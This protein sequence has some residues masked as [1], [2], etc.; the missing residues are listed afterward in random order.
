LLPGDPYR[1]IAWKASGRLGKWVVKEVEQE[2]QNTLWL[3]VDISGTMRHGEWGER[4]L[5]RAIEW[6]ASQA[7]S[8]LKHGGQVGLITF[9]SRVVSVVDCGE[10]SSHR[11][12][13]YEALLDSTEVTDADLTEED[14][15][16]VAQI[17]AGHLRQ[18]EGIALP[19]A[20]PKGSS[21]ADM[22][23]THLRAELIEESRRELSVD[24]SSG[25]L[26]RAYCKSRGLALTHRAEPKAGSKAVALQVALMRAAG[27]RREPALMH[28][29]T[30]FATVRDPAPVIAA[31]KF[32]RGRHHRIEFSLPEGPPEQRFLNNIKAAHEALAYRQS[33]RRRRTAYRL[34][35]PLGARV[36]VLPAI[37]VEGTPSS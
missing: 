36:S 19:R 14:D 18:Q 20:A 12:R 21:L 4:P 16:A 26:L 9:D 34:L 8:V 10:G 28:V 2:V 27:R 5:D 7:D 13:I 6:A 15:D 33:E 24:A 35:S 30:D 1:S 25:D 17:I 3:V 37:R 23:A 31:M 22:V 32:L 29:V 11:L